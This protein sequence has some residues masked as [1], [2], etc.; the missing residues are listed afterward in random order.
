[1]TSSNKIQKIYGTIGK[2]LCTIAGGALGFVVANPIFAIPGLII[3]YVI[4]H[5][6]EKGTVH[7]LQS[8]Q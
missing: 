4:G 5:F 3:G 1:M 2:I 7:L 8:N 6:L